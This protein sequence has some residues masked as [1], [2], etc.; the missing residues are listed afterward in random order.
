MMFK[1]IHVRPEYIC[2]YLCLL[3]STP[4]LTQVLHTVHQW[5][6]GL[7]SRISAAATILS[8]KCLL[9]PAC[10]VSE[11]C[12]AMSSLLIEVLHECPW[13]AVLGYKSIYELPSMLKFELWPPSWG[14]GDFLKYRRYIQG[15]S[16][17]NISTLVYFP[18]SSSLSLTLE[19]AFSAPFFTCPL[20]IKVPQASILAFFSSFCTLFIGDVVWYYG[21]NYLLC[22]WGSQI[23]T[24]ILSSLLIYI[25]RSTQYFS[26]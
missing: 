25:W 11:P 5:H 8:A 24:S 3:E 18:S 20:T 10:Q 15:W 22:A 26:P 14:D 13:W 6:P 7:D 4:L 1:T 16:L 23:L 19:Q 2:H 21:F 9:Y 17:T 12:L